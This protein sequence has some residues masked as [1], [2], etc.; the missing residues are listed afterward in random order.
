MNYF[1]DYNF[2]KYLSYKFKRRKFIQNT[3]NCIIDK[4]FIKILSL[5]INLNYDQIYQ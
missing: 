2:I 4:I 3:L 5:E 1:S